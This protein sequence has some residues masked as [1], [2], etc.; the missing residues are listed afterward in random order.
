MDISSQKAI[1]VQI[2]SSNVFGQK[3]FSAEQQFLQKDISVKNFFLPEKPF[4]AKKPIP[5][6]KPILAESANS[7]RKAIL[8]KM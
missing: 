2:S 1:S 8:T 5:A 4:L 3:A 6:E 7:G